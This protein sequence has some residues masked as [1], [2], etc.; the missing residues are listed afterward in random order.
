LPAIKPD[1]PNV[2]FVLSQF[3]F[4]LRYVAFDTATGEDWDIDAGLKSEITKLVAKNRSDI[5]IVPVRCE[6]RKA[7]AFRS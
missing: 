1:Q 7:F 3:G 4:G 2:S 5:A 6:Y